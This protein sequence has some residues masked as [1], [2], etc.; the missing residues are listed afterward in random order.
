MLIKQKKRFLRNFKGEWDVSFNC[1][2]SRK[3]HCQTKTAENYIFQSFAAQNIA[4]GSE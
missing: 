4:F 3:G 2:T 1:L